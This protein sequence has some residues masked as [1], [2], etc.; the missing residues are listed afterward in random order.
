MR[1][2]GIVEL[3]FTPQQKK[4]FN[5]IKNRLVIK[6]D[7]KFSYMEPLIKVQVKT[8]NWTKKGMLRSPVFVDFVL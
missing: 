7:K 2:V 1:N 4:A 5:S 3:G 8:R 6:E